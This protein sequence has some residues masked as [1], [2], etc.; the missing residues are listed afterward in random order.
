MPARLPPRIVPAETPNLP[1]GHPPRI[2]RDDPLIKSIEA[3]LALLHAKQLC[4]TAGIRHIR[5]AGC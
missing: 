2:Q 1:H 4:I 5:F 3:T